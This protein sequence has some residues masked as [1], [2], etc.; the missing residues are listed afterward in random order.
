MPQVIRPDGLYESQQ[1][2]GLYRWHLPDPIR[3]GDGLRRVEIQALGWRCGGR[4]RSLRDDIASTVWF[5]LD[6]PVTNRPVPPTADT[7]EIG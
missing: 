3:F 4:Y 1:R 2:F 7:M 5:Y 6:R